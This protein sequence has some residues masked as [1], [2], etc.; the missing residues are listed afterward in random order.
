MGEVHKSNFLATWRS[1][2]FFRGGFHF[3]HPMEC[4]HELSCVVAHVVRSWELEVSAEVSDTVIMTIV[5][6]DF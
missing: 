2:I 3:L 5:L 4:C 6:W 1:L